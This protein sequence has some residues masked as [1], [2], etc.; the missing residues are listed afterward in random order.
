MGLKI[1]AE[2]Y[3][4]VKDKLN[5]QGTFNDIRASIDAGHPVV[6]HGYFTRFGHIVVIRGYDEKGFFV[7][8]PNGEYYDTGY[9]TSKTGEC[10]HY[11][12]KLV[13]RTCSPESPQNP[14]HCLIHA[15]QRTL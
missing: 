14:S 2:S 10:L 6:I 15:L 13:G 9:D 3:P 5:Y 7:N 12:Y 11:S 4:K 8:D 1:L